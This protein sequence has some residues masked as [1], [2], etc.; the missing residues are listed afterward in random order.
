MKRGCKAFIT[1]G[2][3]LFAISF[4]KP[5]TA[6]AAGNATM[7]PD[8]AIEVDYQ[9]EVMKVEGNGNTVIYYND[10]ATS[11][12]WEA[13]PVGDDGTAVFDISWIKPGI[14]TR[15]YLKG[16][17]DSSV[18][19]RYIHAEEKLSADFVG[20][21]S[22]ADV[23]DVEEWKNVY[24][25]YPNFTSETG[26]ILFFTKQGGA[27]TAFFDVEQIEWKK[28]NTGNWQPFEELNIAQMNAKGVTLQFRIKAVNDDENGV[29]GKRYSSEAKV[30]IVKTAM[31][32]TVNVNNATMTVGI[33][34]G[35]EYSLDKKNWNLVPAYAKSATG[36]AIS[37]PVVPF[38][39]LPTTNRRVTS[40]SVPM[41]LGVEANAKINEELIQANPGKY[42]YKVN[43]DGQVEGIYVYVR[44]AAGERKSASKIE[45]VLIPF[46][47]S[48]PNITDHITLTY[49][50]TKSG[51]SGVTLTNKTTAADPTVYQ[52]A[53]VDDPDGLTPE[54]LSEL[55]WT[56]LKAAK[57]L[58]VSS[59]R[60]LP[61]QYIIFRVS[62][63]S[64]SELPSNYEK[65]P[66]PIRY[67]KVTYAAISSTS[68]YPGGVIS[69]VTSNN[70]ISGDITY[71]W[72]RSQTSNGNFT[73][74]T[75][76][77]G[78]DSSK[79]TIRDED[80]GYY[81]RVVISNT[82]ASG[83]FAKAT[84]RNSGKI[85]KDPT[86]PTPTPTPDSGP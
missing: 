66:H 62:P 8:T 57:S 60:A 39:V 5:G 56:T 24:A 63:Q 83:E 33:R 68:L 36:D 79:Y 1:L 17:K 3:V 58:N 61:G 64:K 54:E 72:E 45:E 47:A 21:I 49:Q 12:A 28:G 27:Q 59:S 69:A 46:S 81:I 14:T 15:L 52:F 32:P 10:N 29:G 74:I 37:L 23:V 53:V 42:E 73:V 35:M 80:I 71:T 38:D 7:L 26:Y 20:D 11:S 85:I 31:A 30:I 13:V 51:T 77:T 19:A 82:S 40:V 50:N 44:T 67:D 6:K 34:N 76:G 9:Y 86:A 84:S 25:N 48:A 78:Y 41:V 22:A 65:Y 4:M 70:A 16:D 2:G 43:E 55:K 18:T 75:S